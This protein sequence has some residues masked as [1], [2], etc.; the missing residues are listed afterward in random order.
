VGGLVTTYD[1]GM[2]VPDWP[3]TYGYNLF[4]YPWQTWVG[5]PWD[6]FIEHGHRLLGAFVGFV[7]LV[8]AAVVWR[9]E[10]RRWVRWFAVACVVGVIGQGIL[11][12][13]RVLL[14]ERQ[15]AMIHGCIG[16]LF[17]CL[18]VTM[19]T[20]TSRRWRQVPSDTVLTSAGLKSTDVAISADIPMRLTTL[21]WLV[22]AMAFTQ[23]VVG[24]QLRHATPMTTHS[25]F[26]IALFFH[27][28]IAIALFL[29]TIYLAFSILRGGPRMQARS[30]LRRLAIA[31]CGLVTGQIILGVSSWVVKYGVPGWIS[32]F[33][34][35]AGYTV[36]AAT[37]GRAIVVTGHVATGSLIL[38]T[39][40]T[41]ALRASRARWG[42]TGDEREAT[43]VPFI[44]EAV[45]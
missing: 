6:L 1:A 29:H 33:G 28:A 36:T 20:I 16:P 21:A 19:V 35:A 34:I 7:T 2:A 30:A 27:I 39:C 26:R 18:S 41:I 13:M 32:N 38:A 40:L 22:T 4:L 42:I 17:F 37:M 15:L 11:G 44:L 23:I 9:C 8:M 14:D 31:L 10:S 45:A 25:A 5:G 24:A 43:S 12:G 3:T